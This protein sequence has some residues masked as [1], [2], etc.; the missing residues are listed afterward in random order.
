MSFRT[1]SEKGHYWRRLNF[2]HR[3]QHAEYL[4]KQNYGLEEP[5][6]SFTHPPLHPCALAEAVTEVIYVFEVIDLV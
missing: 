3:P 1:L 5:N 6:N 4:A 2:G